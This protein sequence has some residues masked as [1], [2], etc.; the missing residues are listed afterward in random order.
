MSEDEPV[1]GPSPE[2][3]PAETLQDEVEPHGRLQEVLSARRQKLERLRAKGVQPFALSFTK[4][5][6]AAGLHARFDVLGPGEDTGELCSVAGRI[7]LIRRQGRLSFITLRDRTGDIQLFMTEAG[8]GQ[9]YDLI[10]DLDLGDIIGAHGHVMKT[11]RGELSVAVEG[12][13]LLT[14]A[15]RPL[16]EKWKGLRDPEA[17]VRH[18]YLDLASSLESRRP[19]MARAALLKAF[20]KVLDERG[21]LE[22]ETPVLQPI[23]GGALARPFVTHH[24]ALGLDMYLRISLELYLKRL[25]VGGLERIYEIGR[26]FR[27]E[28]VD[29]NHSPEFTMLEV[30]QAYGDYG[31]MMELT[32]SLVAESARAL[33]GSLQFPFKDQE[34]SVEPPWPRI[35]VLGSL[36]KVLGEEIALDRPDLATLAE[37]RGVPVD[38][39]R[40]P[41]KIVVDLWEHLVGPTLVQPTFVMD[42]PRDVSPLARPNRRDPMLTEHVDPYM[43]GIELGTAYSELTDPDDQRARFEAQQEA[44]RAGDEEAHPLDEDFLTALEHG[45]PPAGGLGIGI[46]RLLAI[47]ADAASLREVIAFPHLRPESG[48][49][50]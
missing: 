17:R 2:G 19:L 23:A 45:M 30:Y 34:L 18:R 36:S 11:R 41:G 37:R 3:D 16:P 8:S 7:M 39:R 24:Q 12:L 28:G 1:A 48:R 6:E 26:T 5:A 20:R 10:D 21:F 38:P 15:L 40:V 42:F 50:S 35:T 44:R 47:L 33:H 4:T 9:A 32:E 46:D 31:T 14:K 22:V 49:D 13:T 25:L 27:N 29:R 43:A